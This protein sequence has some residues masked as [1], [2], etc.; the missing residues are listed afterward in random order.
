MGVYIE[1][2]KIKSENKIYYY[3]VSTKDFGNIEPFEIGIDSAQK[4]LYLFHNIKDKEKNTI[5]LSNPKSA[6]ISWLPSG[7]LGCVL[8][9]VL[10]TLEKQEFGEYLSFSS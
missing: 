1:I 9:K 6:N 7:L 2:K 10:Q 3:R 4:V 5:D 8:Y